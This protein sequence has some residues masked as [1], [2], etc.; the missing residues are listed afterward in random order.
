MLNR[1]Y[2]EILQI[3]VEEKVK[4]I[5]VGAYALGVHGV[6]RATGDI[7]IFVKADAEN[8]QR[9]YY[10]LI[11]FGAPVSELSP[12]DF[13]EDEIIFQIGIAPRRIDIITSIDGVTFDEAYE[14]CVTAEVEG[15]NIPVLS[16]DALIKNKEATGR[17]KDLLDVRILKKHLGRE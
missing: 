11:R 13:N 1:D 2:R 15:L 16:V 14:N 3:F 9:I 12:L 17:E 10:S 8:S 6:P 4:F 7:D 5:V